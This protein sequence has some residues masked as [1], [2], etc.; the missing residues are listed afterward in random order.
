MAANQTALIDRSS[1]IWVH[2]CC[3]TY[4]AQVQLANE[5]M[6]VE[7][8]AKSSPWEHSAILLTCIKR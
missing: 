3:K 1:L 4:V 8:I 2:N 6:K 5:Q 7:S